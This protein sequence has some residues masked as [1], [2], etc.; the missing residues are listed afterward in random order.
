M[1]EHLPPVKSCFSTTVTVNPLF[2]SRAAVAI[3]PAPAPD[4]G[5]QNYSGAEAL[6]GSPTTM[7]VGEGVFILA[8]F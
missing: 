6:R 2:A 4:T 7:T 5:S 3:P 1:S 8:G